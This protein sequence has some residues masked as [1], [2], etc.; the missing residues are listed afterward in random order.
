METK[1]P[2]TATLERILAI[3][4]VTGVTLTDPMGDVLH[5]SAGDEGMD[6][7]IAFFSGMLPSIGDAAG[8]G[9]IHQAILKSPQDDSLLLLAEKEQTLGVTIKPR[10][11]IAGVS[12]QIMTVLQ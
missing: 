12:E 6:E 11:P 4:G 10:V 2:T 5:S 3:P 7:L 1:T 8:V 9:Y